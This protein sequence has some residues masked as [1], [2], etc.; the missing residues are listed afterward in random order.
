MIGPTLLVG[1]GG[2]GSEII[3][4]VANMASEEERAHLGFVAMDT[5]INE[6][7]E[8][9]RKNPFIRTIQTST[10]LS[11]GEYLEIDQHARD[12]WFPVNAILNSKTLSEGAGQVR[13]IS[14]LAF[15][16][17]LRAGKLEPLHEAVQDL[18]KL[19]AEQSE[20][21]LK[22]IVVSSLAG[23]TGSGLILPVSLYLKNY[24]RTHFRQSANIMR[25]FFI[26]PEVFDEVI[27]GHAERS[28]LRANAY[29]TIREIDAF[30][31]KGDETL[32]PRFKDSVRME[33]PRVSSREY[34]D[35][36]VRPLDF[37]FLFDAQNAEGSKLN[38]FE[39]YID[40]A[41]NCIYAQ[42]IGPMNK[43]SNSSEDNTIRR[44]CEE[45][46]RNRYAG[47]GSSML[48]YPVEDLK[49]YIALHWA[50]ENVSKQWLYFDHEYAQLRKRNEEQ[51]GMG[52]NVRDLDPSK[53]YIQTVESKAKQKMPFAAA[54][55]NSCVIYDSEGYE[56]TSD[57]WTDYVTALCGKIK[58]DEMEADS[59]LDGQLEQARSTVNEVT[60]GEDSW[61][62]LLNAYE[63]L[64]KYKTMIEH[65][66]EEVSDIIAYTMF[67]APAEAISEENV[68]D[69]RLDWRLE[70]YMRNTKGDFIH[71]NAVRYFLYKTR[72]ELEAEKIDVEKKLKKEK[73]FFDNFEKQFDDAKTPAV[74][75]ADNLADR[76]VNLINK[77]THKLT[78]EQIGLREAYRSYLLTCNEYRVNATLSRVL[79]EGIRYI[80]D[81][82][83]AFEVFYSTFEAK[84]SKLDQRI[85]LLGKRYESSKGTTKRYVCASE[86]CMKAMAK[87][88]GYSGG[89]ISIDSE[90]AESIYS[91]VRS[92]A[93]MDDKPMDGSY[94]SDLFD[95]Q[96]IGY[97]K[98]Q[99]TEKYGVK[100]EVNVI[101]ALENEARLEGGFTRQDE[102]DQYVR[103]AISSTRFLSTPFIEKPLGEE[104]DRINAC[105]INPSLYPNDESPRG[106]LVKKELLNFGG[107]LDE[108]ISK[109]MILFYQS[110]YGLRANNLS[111]F[112]PPKESPTNS[113]P[114]GEY[115]KAYFELISQI[116]P[117]SNRSR[118]ITPHIDRWWHVVTKMPDL[119]E[120][121][122]NAQLERIN[123]AF[124]WGLITNTVNYSDISTGNPAYRLKV[125]DLGLE[126]ASDVLTV[127]NGTPCNRLY[128]VLDAFAIY[129]ELV[130]KMLERIEKMTEVDVEKSISLDDGLLKSNLGTFRIN[131]FRN[132]K[133]NNVRSVFDI[134]VLMK[135]SI[136]SDFYDEESV[137]AVVSV[138][139]R[140]F[141]KYFE[142]MSEPKDIPT[143]MG[144]VLQKQFELFVDDMKGENVD[145]KDIYHDNLFGRISSIVAKA[146]EDL[147]MEKE[148]RE[149]AKKAK[150]LAK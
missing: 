135:K 9:Q 57:A 66:S 22:I 149:I 55:V 146:F 63:E 54:I 97:Y 121:N 31:M 150:D 88:C 127:S 65:H 30:L 136:S 143:E 10:R 113:R 140:E 11:V 8:I 1:L 80:G 79:T 71:P 19:E 23:G 128:E 3:C 77:L 69:G 148:S 45:N 90:L 40:H 33:F 21:A 78:G 34:E 114:G 138:A 39:Q 44:L 32:H 82:C 37:C 76:K 17:T 117:E 20:Q 133:E 116:R 108:D 56:K 103:K 59:E 99:L 141:R 43:R 14:R 51:R 27:T 98:D 139:I 58:K 102:I 49:E 119:D 42:S 129:P 93:M 134:P 75:T 105:A 95:K 126:S 131:E 15:D 41:A 52:L 94:F 122:E 144:A 53:I 18:Y 68:T 123:A 73:Q 130:T 72:E 104:R 74:E 115:Y 124:F 62:S 64:K 101:D 96:I 28:S 6:L 2:K 100:L 120:E 83:K 87:D 118:A 36:K 48:I 38:S 25:G 35:F 60:G 142:R 81:V 106:M 50:K 84:V 70:T 5:D 109:N 91:M 29:A 112:A 110:F 46:G 86:K 7:R 111:K 12:T 24:L 26:L 16:T 125:D 13:A 85:T 147:G 132:G 47:A 4:R 145:G 61:V 92:Y 67:R 137:L 89:V 107:V